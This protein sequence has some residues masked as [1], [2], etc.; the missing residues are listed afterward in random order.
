MRFITGK[1]IDYVFH[2]KD[3]SVTPDSKMRRDKAGFLFDK[4]FGRF[5]CH[6]FSLAPSPPHP[7]LLFLLLMLSCLS[8]EA[9]LAI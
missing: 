4:F 1:L 3:D 2:G 7:L 6:A 5:L 9:V 8:S